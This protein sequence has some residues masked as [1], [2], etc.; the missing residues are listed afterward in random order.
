M[1]Q[2]PLAGGPLPMLTDPVAAEPLKTFHAESTSPGAEACA[3]ECFAQLSRCL[4]QEATSEVCL[5][6]AY[7]SDRA[8]MAGLCSARDKWLAGRE[9]T[10]PLTMVVMPAGAAP[11]V[12]I[13]VIARCGG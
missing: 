3:S 12:E 4:E 11:S 7:I 6:Q 8:M 9:E 10:P 1:A 5:I 2:N 13:D